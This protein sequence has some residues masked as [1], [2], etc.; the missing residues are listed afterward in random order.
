[1]INY[2]NGLFVFV[3]PADLSQRLAAGG[4]YFESQTR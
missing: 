1:M 4:V 3:K 2:K